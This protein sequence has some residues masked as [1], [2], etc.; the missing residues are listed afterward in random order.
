LVAAL[1]L[2]ISPLPAVA[3]LFEGRAGSGAVIRPVVIIGGVVPAGLQAIPQNGT[4]ELGVSIPELDATQP[5]LKTQDPAVPAAQIQIPIVPA[6][7]GE[8]AAPEAL[9]V[10]QAVGAK[11]EPAAGGGVSGSHDAAQDEGELRHAFDKWAD[12]GGASGPADAVVPESNEAPAAGLP[13]AAG[14]AKPEG[15]ATLP[16]PAPPAAKETPG[17]YNIFPN[18]VTGSNLAS[19]VLAA[20]FAAQG[21]IVPAA[22]AIIAANV[23]DMLDGR[24]ARALK[25]KNPM[26]IDLDSLADVVSFGAAPALLIFKAALLP[27]LGWWGFPIAAAFAFGGM[28]RL[29]RFNVG[30]HAEEAGTVPHKKSDSF[31]GLPI[32]GGAGVIAA[33]AL[34]L[35]A[36][37]AAF[38][39]PFAIAATLLAAG[40]M[41]SKLPYPAFKKGGAKALIAPAAVGL[42]AV[43]PLAVLGLYSFIPASV[44]GLYLLTGPLIALWQGGS[45]TW[46]RELKRK[47][48]HQAILLAIPAYFLIGAA[49][50]PLAAAIWVGLTGLVELVR[51]KVPAARPFFDHWFGRI[52]REKELNRLSGSFYV[53]LGVGAVMA[54][55]ALLHLS[56]LLVPAAVLA[57]A[58]GDAA[59]PL[60]GLRFG[61]K[62][63]KVMGT[64]RSVDGTAAGFAVAAA[65]GLAL[66][67]PWFAALGAAVAFTLVDV[68]P[69]KPDDNLWIPIVYAAALAL[70]THL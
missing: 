39:A 33:A 12:E 65:I 67:F 20:F 60:V 22:V 19:G 46:K 48:F 10:L 2:E 17:W 6:A 16:P 1:L 15:S 55:V 45:A 23:F 69:V 26:G 59:S 68:F 14:E 30:A 62:P 56:P 11:L 29:A 66:G 38:V 61:F 4:M 13:R 3:A 24:T 52:I 21:L 42:A 31:T 8:A 63:Y 70:L 34:A 53:A 44:F 36:L 5:I 49:H 40:A 32:P 51:L 57:L 18:L 27:A 43:I 37:P 47:G 28:Y 50:I 35:A 7:E 58:L 64:Q 41:V 25:V 54:A 9:P